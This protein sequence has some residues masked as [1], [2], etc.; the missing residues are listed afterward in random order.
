M[1]VLLLPALTRKVKVALANRLPMA[2]LLLDNDASGD[3]PLDETTSL[4]NPRF[5]LGS[6]AD[7]RGEIAQLYAMQIAGLIL[8]QNPQEARTLLVGLGLKGKLASDYESQE[9]RDLI[10]AVLAMVSDSRVW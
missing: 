8:A 7:P 2:P 5:L 4:V 10:H 3:D 9:A 6:V 1:S